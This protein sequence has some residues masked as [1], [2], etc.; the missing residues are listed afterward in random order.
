MSELTHSIQFQLVGGHPC[1]DFTNTLDNRGSS[2]EI[3]LI[4]SYELL[5]QFAEQCGTFSAADIAKLRSSAEAHRLK[6]GTA[7]M[8][9]IRLRETTFQIFSAI[10]NRKQPS[11]ASLRHLNLLVTEAGRHRIVVPRAEGFAWR[12]DDIGADPKAVVWPFAWM[13]AELLASDELGSVRECASPSCSWLFLDKSKSHSR[14]WCDM[15]VCGNRLKV[16]RF[17][18][19]TRAQS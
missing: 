11:Q 16:R 14:R 1:L 12:W 4:S 8:D 3:E 6:A 17:Y 15:K 7:I 9:A 10:A 2:N 19:R 18:E 13:A 5:L